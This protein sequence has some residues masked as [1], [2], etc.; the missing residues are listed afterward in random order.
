MTSYEAVFTGGCH[1]RAL[2]FDLF[3]PGHP[4]SVPARRCT[5]SYCMRFNGTWTSHPDAILQLV[6][7]VPALRYR[8]GTCTA[9]FLVCSVCGVVVAAV[10]V[11]DGSA[12]AVVNINTLD[13]A[14]SIDFDHSDSNFDRESLQ[15]RRDRRLTRWM[16]KVSFRSA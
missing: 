10:S 11:L 2:R 3:W 16:R 6:E 12:R 5:C 9:D 8:F 1:C 13:D 7:S 15:E 4:G 14:G